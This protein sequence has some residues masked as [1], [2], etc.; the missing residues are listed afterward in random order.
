MSLNTLDDKYMPIIK[1]TLLASPRLCDNIFANQH[2]ST[3]DD[4]Q[5]YTNMICGLSVIRP[6]SVHSLPFAN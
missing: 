4:D 5:F 1:R 3:I 2:H 6:F